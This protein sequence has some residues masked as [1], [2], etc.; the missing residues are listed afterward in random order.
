MAGARGSEQG[1][2][3]PLYTHSIPIPS[4][5]I[6][7]RRAISTA[8]SGLIKT[9][10]VHRAISKCSC[11]TSKMKPTVCFPTTAKFGKSIPKWWHWFPFNPLGY[12]LAP[13]W[14]MTVLWF[15]CLL[16][17]TIKSAVMRFGDIDTFRRLSPLMLGLV[18]G[19]FCAAVFWV[20][21]NMARGWSVPEFPHP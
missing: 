13:T 2:S 20:L 11:M 6:P 15:P 3:E 10:R 5:G 7:V 4:A 18:L 9:A 19:K 16:A 17:W 21:G 12:V 1:Y 8:R 14:A